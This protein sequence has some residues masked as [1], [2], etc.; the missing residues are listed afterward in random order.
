MTR[1]RAHGLT[2][3][4]QDRLR[5]VARRENR[6]YAE[7]LQHYGLERYLYRLSMTP[8]SDRFVLKGALLMRV[9]DGAETRATR[10]IDLLGPT[11][12]SAEEVEQLIRDCATVEVAPDGVEIVPNSVRV[13]PIRIPDKHVGFRAKFD[14]FMAKSRLRFQVDVGAGDAVVPEPVQLEYPVL[15]AFPAP[16][17]RAYTP[18]TTIAEKFEAIVKLDLANTRMKDYFDLAALAANLVF[19]GEILRSAVAGTFRSRGIEVPRETPPGLGDGFAQ[20]PEKIVQ[21]KAFVRKSRLEDRTWPLDETVARI[22]DFLMPAVRAAAE[23]E[24]FEMM[25]SPGGPWQSP[26]A[27]RKRSH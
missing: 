7:I 24:L 14:G 17:L 10:D 25:W 8:Q 4:V 5:N 18:Y 19:D 15:L 11:D 27:E 16:R 3:S 23:D 1:P 21:W 9:W 2:R 22:R 6:P 13:T 20:A 26:A 12:V